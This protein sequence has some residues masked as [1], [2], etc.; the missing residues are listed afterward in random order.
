M[1]LMHP[2]MLGLDGNH[3]LLL[4]CKQDYLPPKGWQGLLDFQFHQDS[5]GVQCVR[6]P[7]DLLKFQHLLPQ[8]FLCLKVPL[9]ALHSLFHLVCQVLLQQ[10]WLL[11]QLDLQH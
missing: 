2:H 5:L 7:L 3:L 4:F 11:C 6:Y 1:H 10:Q 8:A 9:V